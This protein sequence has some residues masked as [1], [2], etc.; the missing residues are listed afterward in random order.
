[1]GDAPQLIYRRAFK[2]LQTQYEGTD[3]VLDYIHKI[4]NQLRF[5]AN[6]GNRAIT[7][8]LRS[9]R[10]TTQVA[11]TTYPPAIAWA[12]ESVVVINNLAHC[13]PGEYVRISKTIDV[14]L[15][16]GRFPDRTDL[17]TALQSFKLPIDTQVYSPLAGRR[18]SDAPAPEWDQ[19]HPPCLS[20]GLDRLGSHWLLGD[21][22][23]WS[24]PTFTGDGDVSPVLPPEE[25][26]LVL[27]PTRL[28]SFSTSEGF[29]MFASAS[30]VGNLDPIFALG[31]AIDSADGASDEPMM[32]LFPYD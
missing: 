29:N 26:T 18:D 17:P 31:S 1:M 32:N 13:P 19:E 8:R 5:E 15:A 11:A 12:A 4:I 6:S 2:I 14:S 9:N 7:D 21:Y 16:M 28:E 24:I 3:Q 20:S 23:E 22:A 25:N 30:T 27:T 10:S